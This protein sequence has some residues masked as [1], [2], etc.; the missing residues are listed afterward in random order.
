MLIRTQQGQMLFTA[1]SYESTSTGPSTPIETYANSFTVTLNGIHLMDVVAA[2]Y[3]RI[4][5]LESL[6]VPRQ[7]I[8]EIV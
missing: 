8:I 4:F 5:T 1:S 7:D 3:G 2:I 6:F